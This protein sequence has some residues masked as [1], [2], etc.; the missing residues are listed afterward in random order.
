[1][2]R[3]GV[4]AIVLAFAAAGCGNST[5][6]QSQTSPATAD[7]RAVDRLSRAYLQTYRAVAS[8][9][10]NRLSREYD[11]CPLTRSN[12]NGSPGRPGEQQFTVLNQAAI[13]QAMLPHYR[14]LAR[15]IAR[16]NRGAPRLQAA[17]QAMTIV[18]TA[19][20]ALRGADTNYCSILRKWAAR[21][22]D[23]RFDVAG[24]IGASILTKPPTRRV[25]AAYST[26]KRTA[27][28]LRGAG[29][30]ARDI[31][32]LLRFTRLFWSPDA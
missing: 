18:A 27:L 15:D 7:A 9:V 25:D 3:A 26:L 1:M 24:A 16:V 29:G 21:H 23:P 11:T 32:L 13:L 4:C 20:R 17:S 14:A 31:N 12:P 28:A 30:A 19:Y 22:W 6:P 2:S 10:E 8:R 5:K